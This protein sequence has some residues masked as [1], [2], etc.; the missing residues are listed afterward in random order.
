[1]ATSC[2]SGMSVS[3]CDTISAASRVDIS[4]LV[5]GPP[6]TPNPI[7]TNVLPPVLKQTLSDCDVSG[8]CKFVGYDFIR[9]AAESLSSIPYTLDR[10]DT[11]A[12]D[13]AVFTKKTVR[14][15][16]ISSIIPDGNGNVTVTT[17][18]SHGFLDTGTVVLRTPPYSG[19]FPIQKVESPTIFTIATNLP[20][21]DG[22]KYFP[23][24]QTCLKNEEYSKCPDGDMTAFKNSNGT[25][26][27]N[28]S[29]PNVCP[30]NGQ[31][32][33]GYTIDTTWSSIWNVGCNGVSTYPCRMPIAIQSCKTAGPEGEYTRMRASETTT[34]CHDTLQVSIAQPDLTNATLDY[35]ENPPNFTSPLGFELSNGSLTGTPLNV[36]Y[37]Q[38]NFIE[39]ECANACSTTDTCQGFNVLTST[40]SCEF[41]SSVGSTV[42]DPNKIAFQ[43]NPPA[44][45]YN[46]STVSW[47]TPGASSSYIKDSGGLVSEN[48]GAECL[49]MKACNEDIIK[50]LKNAPAT[51]FTFKTTILKTCKGCIPKTFTRT[52]QTGLFGYVSGLLDEFKNV[53]YEPLTNPQLVSRMVY[54]AKNT[55]VRHNF[56]SS[57]I[58]QTV[59][60]SNLKSGYIF[61]MKIDSPVYKASSTTSPLTYSIVGSSYYSRQSLKTPAGVLYKYQDGA[62]QYYSSAFTFENVDY[63]HE[64]Y[65]IKAFTYTD[66]LTKYVVP[67]S[68]LT[69]FDLSTNSP[70]DYD[71]FSPE[72][73]KFVF[74]VQSSCQAGQKLTG[75]TCYTC[76]QNK[77]CPVGTFKEIPC[78]AGTYT[79]GTGSST[80]IQCPAGSYCLEGVGPQACPTGSFCP[81]GSSLPTGC[82]TGMSCPSS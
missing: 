58:G 14:T 19:N 69:G 9:D 48:T 71:K 42:Y 12:S 74:M 49:N 65:F 46:P 30:T 36:R 57:Q 77:Y 3:D 62:S 41:F 81:A 59:K 23:S 82:P 61:D 20:C 13:T 47:N 63:I 29:I 31:C 78:P 56:D 67:N 72:Y 44:V 55:P 4:G 34:T 25:A 68:T 15:L 10:K 33:S 11:T 70:Y 45:V 73:N 1:M 5:N 2:P 6:P 32:P 17:T 64:G 50:A 43:R 66:G 22:F 60:L 79:T 28:P 7:M 24:L 51:G 54:T 76:N 37:G 26:C 8:T 40:N 53:T 75:V 38:S 52:T 21:P 27:Y 80:C 35:F 18:T 16:G 39:E